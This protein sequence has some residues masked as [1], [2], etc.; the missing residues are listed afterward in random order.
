[1]TRTNLVAT[2]EKAPKAAQAAGASGAKISGLVGHESLR[3]QVG[4]IKATKTRS[5]DRG[6]WV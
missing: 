4:V 6:V 5:T 1:M 3:L 2:H